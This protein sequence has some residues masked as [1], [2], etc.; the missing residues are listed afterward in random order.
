MGEDF[1]EDQVMLLERLKAYC[2]KRGL[3]YAVSIYQQQIDL[4]LN[5]LAKIEDQDGPHDVH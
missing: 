3:P 1:L 2:E 5:E 4:I